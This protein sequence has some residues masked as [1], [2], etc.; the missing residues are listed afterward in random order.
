MELKFNLAIVSK[1]NQTVEELLKPYLRLNVKESLEKAILKRKN[2]I[3][4][5]IFGDES[6]EEIIVTKDNEY[7][8][9]S[10]IK[11]IDWKKQKDYY[12]EIIG[13]ETLD[14]AEKYLITNSVITPDGKWHGMIPLD[15]LGVGFPKKRSFKEYLINY[16]SKYIEPYEQNGIVTILECK[17]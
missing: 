9:T 7:V 13:G 5:V 12:K 4:T 15:L 11:N 17:M 3:T 14:C 6:E 16:Y 2:F 8:N 10:K 1:E